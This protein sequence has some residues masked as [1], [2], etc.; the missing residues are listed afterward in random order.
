MATIFSPKIGDIT[1]TL[2]FMGEVDWTL[3]I[4][5]QNSNKKIVEKWIKNTKYSVTFHGNLQSISPT[6]Q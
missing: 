1:K 2:Y 5:K 4:Y 3:V 6:E